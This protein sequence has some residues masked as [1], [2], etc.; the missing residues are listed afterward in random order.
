[1]KKKELKNLA[2]KIATLEKE[3]EDGENI[4]EKQDEIMR[5]MSKCSF[6][7]LMTLEEYIS[8]FLTL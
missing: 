3:L 6:M 8:K 1:M 7:D 4:Q 5:L 2:K